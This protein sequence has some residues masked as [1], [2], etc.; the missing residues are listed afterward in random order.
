MADPDHWQDESEFAVA[1]DHYNGS[2][3]PRSQP[4]AGAEDEVDLGERV[5]FHCH[6]TQATPVLD[7]G[8]VDP[9]SVITRAAT[10]LHPVLAT[11][12]RLEAAKPQF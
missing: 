3:P 11:T 7:Q 5:R 2:L 12:R 8:L 1:F 4:S 6:P 9:G 10:F